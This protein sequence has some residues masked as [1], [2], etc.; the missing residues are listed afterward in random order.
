L[1]ALAKA[2]KLEEAKE[3]ARNAMRERRGQGESDM[4]ED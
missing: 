4:D 1:V 2:G 3:G